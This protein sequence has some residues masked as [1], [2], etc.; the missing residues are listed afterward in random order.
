MSGGRTQTYKSPGRIQF[1]SKTLHKSILYRDGAQLDGDCSVSTRRW[2]RLAACQ[3]PTLRGWAQGLAE[4]LP[5]LEGGIS[6]FWKHLAVI[7]V[8]VQRNYLFTY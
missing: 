6:E 7:Y 8:I 3:P 4:F 2:Q 1:S 5:T